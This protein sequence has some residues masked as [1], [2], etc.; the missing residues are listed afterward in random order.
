M[1][2]AVRVRAVRMVFDDVLA[3]DAVDLDVAG[4]R[5]HG[6]LGPNG[7]GKTTLLGLLLGLLAP[8]SG[9]VEVLG[10]PVVRGAVLPAGV[11]GFL[12]APGLYPGLTARANLM[13]VARLAG[14]GGAAGSRVADALSRVGLAEVADDRV[15]GFSLGM[16][17]RLGLA[18]ALVTE[19]RLVILDEPA[20]GLDPQGR[21]LVQAVLED[22]AADGAAVVVS[23]HR[24]DDLADWCDEAT[25]L[26]AGRAVFSGP[27]AKLAAEC[28]P[29][30]HRVVVAEPQRARAIAETL[31]GLTVLPSP[32]T[33]PDTVVV[34]GE[35]A[36]IEEFAA[37]VVGA[38]AGLRSLAPVVSP[39]E[40]AFVRLTGG[41]E[42]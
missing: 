33:A 3:L 34:R 10:V 9:S 37:A 39:L 5:V 4:G 16:R 31:P 15:R 23:S 27:L 38:G 26:A 1:G 42:A 28:G 8:R 6:V 22:L 17:Q 2:D 13:A 20:N 35:T 40:A 29:L 24:M 36:A 11:A 41:E 18:G 30:E 12:D 21:R 32:R 19:P 25:V 7:A 14:A